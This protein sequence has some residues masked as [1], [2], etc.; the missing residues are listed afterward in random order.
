MKSVQILLPLILIGF[1]LTQQAN[2]DATGDTYT[3]APLAQDGAVADFL[4]DLGAVTATFDGIDEIIGANLVGAAGDVFVLS[5]S[6]TDLGGGL[7]E[8][9]VSVATFD[10][11]GAPTIWIPAGALSSGGLV[12]SSWRLDVGDVAAGVNRIGWGGDFTV[13]SSHSEVFNSAG[14]SLG[15]FGLSLDSSLSPEGVSGVMV[16]G[17]GGGDVGGFDFHRY[18]MRWTVQESVPEPATATLGLVGLVGLLCTRRRH[19]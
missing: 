9:E 15:T 8:I 14:G 2:A 6:E 11:S 18:T 3:V 5:E 1:V 12:Y 19:K 7:M 17:L 10:A 13:V 4:S 16:I